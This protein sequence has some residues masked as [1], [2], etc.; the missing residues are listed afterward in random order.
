MKLF[1]SLI[2]FAL[3]NTVLACGNEY[4]YPLEKYRKKMAGLTCS[5][6]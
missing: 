3:F 6:S 4:Y 1:F 2:L 5:V